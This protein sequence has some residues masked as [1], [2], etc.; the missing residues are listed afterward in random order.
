MIERIDAVPDQPGQIARGQKRG[1]HA[2]T[3]GGIRH[4]RGH[5]RP[6]KVHGPKTRI[7]PL[8]PIGFLP[9]VGRGKPEGHKIIRLY[10]D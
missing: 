9:F 7:E 5:H 6:G 2:Q 10:Q 8:D 1:I 3:I 4:N